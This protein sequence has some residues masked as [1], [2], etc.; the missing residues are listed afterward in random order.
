MNREKPVEMKKKGGW[1]FKDLLLVPVLL[2]TVY[3]FYLMYYASWRIV[4][5]AYYDD[6]LMV[7]NAMALKQWILSGF[8]TQWL[9]D[10]SPAILS[11]GLSYPFFLALFSLLN[12]PYPF[13]FCL[14][15]V[16]SCLIFV[17]A[18]RPLKLNRYVQWLVYLFLLY[19]PV[20]F[21]VSIS[22]RI[23]RNAVLPWAVILVVSCFTAIYLRMDR[24]VKATIPWTVLGCLSFCW[25]WYLREDSVWLLPYVAV[26]TILGLIFSIL[27]KTFSWKR[28]L[29]AVLPFVCL[30]AVKML[31]SE[32]NLV[33]YGIFT[34]NDRNHS[35]FTDVMGLLNKIDDGETN[36]DTVWISRRS[37]QLAY[38]ASPTLDSLNHL[39][40]V[41]DQVEDETGEARGDFPSWAIRTAA[42]EDGYYKDAVTT[43]AL[44]KKIKSELT[45]AYKNGK[46]VARKGFY[47]SPLV[48]PVTTDDLKKNFTFSLIVSKNIVL[49]YMECQM[50]SKNIDASDAQA[51]A[52]QTVLHINLGSVSESVTKTENQVMN[53]S[54]RIVQSFRTI[55]YLLAPL[56]AVGYI[57]LT[58]EAFLILFKKRS[59]V[60]FVLPSW[61]IST[62][63][64]MTA[65]LE[66]YIAVLFISFIKTN[67]VADAFYFYSSGAYALIAM[68]ECITIIMGVK[69][70]RR[71]F[72][73]KRNEK[74]ALPSD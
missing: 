10:Y 19:N 23:Y 24:K 38:A 33:N 13:A 7:N 30:Y 25:F 18:I 9:G 32:I 57:L 34:T 31:Y 36:Q 16:F 1:G 52:W 2:L 29:L 28:I 14:L 61:F 60:E 42:A 41:W 4:A 69:I 70:I 44:F 5:N 46:L 39:D 66:T 63:M 73:F 8:S 54:N 55:A 71:R 56:M 48:K 58:I 72:I 27:K 22:M 11:K 68:T 47:V 74:A 64:L 35:S 20:G 26:I 67:P 3:R 62:G 43:E 40:D 51:A 49:H 65:F 45:E 6:A 53:T 59:S 15:I 50:E 17:M 12:I 37:L 21:A